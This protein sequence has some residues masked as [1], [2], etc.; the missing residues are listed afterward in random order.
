MSAEPRV[1][2][3]VAVYNPGEYFPGLVSSLLGQSLAPAAFEVVFVDDGSTDGT[4]ARLDELAAAHGHFQ[5]IHIPN[6]GWPGRP[7]NIGIERARGRYV[8]FVDHD[9]WLAPEALERLADR[10][11]RNDADVVLGKEVGHG[12]GVPLLPFGR[13]VDDEPFPSEALVALL[14]PH[15]LFRRA[16]L[17]EH[18]IRFPEG[19]RRLEDHQF[20]IPAYFAARRISILADYPCYHWIERGGKENATHTR[21]DP[22]AY[23]S[24]MRDILDIVDARTAPGDVRDRLYAH[25]F[26]G[27]TLHKLRGPAWLDHERLSRHSEI[28]FEEM[29]HIT[30]ERFGPSVDRHIE[31][32][33]RIAA[34]AVRAGSTGLIAAHARFTQDVGLWCETTAVSFGPGRLDLELNVT[35]HG[36]DGSPFRF[37]TTEAG[38]SWIAPEELTALDVVRASDL[39]IGDEATRTTITIIAR[40]R[41]SRVVYHR[42][43]PFE[44]AIDGDESRTSGSVSL[45]L[46]LA[47]LAGGGPLSNGIWDLMVRVDSC[48]WRGTRP[49]PGVELPAPTDGLS[50]RPYVTRA[51]NL[52]LTVSGSPAPELIGPPAPPKP[53]T[54]PLTSGDRWRRVKRR[55]PPRVRRI[56][57]DVL[58]RLPGG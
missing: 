46:D 18:D 43:F 5:A 35:L 24:N 57:R 1:S 49:I 44:L 29:R 53:V 40:H 56:G 33:Y 47:T 51:G 9:D 12:F 26:R 20:V 36:P 52:A 7:R 58:D 31:L 19:R 17:M 55:L 8:Y 23:Y 22:V 14:T 41:A 37:A 45:T 39:E 13:S 42:E 4:G 54:P 34:Q 11:D 48:G 15:K 27:K 25:W 10:A 28:L 21:I 30:A 2:V 38:T 6:S 16:M 32:R 50:T 3:I